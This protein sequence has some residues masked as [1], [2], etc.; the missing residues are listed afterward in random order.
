MIHDRIL[1]LLPETGNWKLEIKKWQPSAP[2]ARNKREI[3]ATKARNWR[4]K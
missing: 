4:E 1:K 2:P 3:T